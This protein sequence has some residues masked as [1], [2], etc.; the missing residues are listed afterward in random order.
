M[1]KSI[2][3]LHFDRTRSGKK[4]MASSVLATVGLS[5]SPK[6]SSLF[7]FQVSIFSSRFVAVSAYAFLLD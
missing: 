5:M 6:I 1:R 2:V 7:S 3:I 4:V